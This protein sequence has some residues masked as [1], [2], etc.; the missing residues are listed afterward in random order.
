MRMLG[1]TS[2]EMTLVNAHLSDRAVVED[3]Q[4]V[5]GPGAVLAGRIAAELRAGTLPTESVEWLKVNFSKTKLKLRH[6]FLL[7]QKGAVRVRLVPELR[8]VRDHAG[9]CTS[10]S[11]W[12]REQKL[13]ADAAARGWERERHACA[14]RR[15][16]A[17]RTG[18]T[19]GGRAERRNPLSP[20]RCVSSPRKRMRDENCPDKWRY[21]ES[22]MSL[23]SWVRSSEVR[24]TSG[25]IGNVSN[26]STRSPSTVR[27][28]SESR[29]RAACERCDGHAQVWGSEAGLGLFT[30]SGI[31]PHRSSC[32]PA[33]P[34]PPKKTW[35]H[36]RAEG[37][38]RLGANK[39]RH[40]LGNLAARGSKASPKMRRRRRT[41]ARTTA[42]RPSLMKL[43]K[44]LSQG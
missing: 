33:T 2:T 30:I 10:P 7:P 17:G 18:R 40:H 13:A 6:C 12:R 25:T 23:S 8:Q 4:R 24:Q 29:E 44:L 43:F 11:R 26:S 39:V 14:A 32:S 36:S 21:S 41:D 15:A 3:Y 37:D 28:A 9:V 34:R 42:P 22:R 5:L 16:I 38:S 1:H 31:H 35:S 20:M 19:T 27:M